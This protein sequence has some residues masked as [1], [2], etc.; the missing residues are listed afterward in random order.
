MAGSQDIGFEIPD[1]D[2][3]SYTKF[4]PTYPDSLFSRIYEY[5]RWHCDRWVVVHD[6]GS[7]AGIA[8]AVL[9]KRFDTIAVSEP[10][11][12]YLD[13]ARERLKHLNVNAKLIFHQS[14]A[15]DQSWLDTDSLDM[16]TIFTAIGYADLDLLMQELSRVLK[17]DATFAVI[18]YNG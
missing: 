8:A 18:N 10:N 17:P 15:E 2:W 9:A 16:F 1:F 13:V 6:A 3:E 11:G 5:H 12:A 7:G 14:T 4:R